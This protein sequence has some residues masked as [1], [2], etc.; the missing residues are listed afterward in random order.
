MRANLGRFFF[1]DGR[2]PLGT[3]HLATAVTLRHR[4]VPEL[5]ERSG[6]SAMGQV[7]TC[8]TRCL[9]MTIT[10]DGSGNNAVPLL[11]DGVLNLGCT[12]AIASVLLL[13]QHD[14]SW[15]LNIT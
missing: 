14:S 13:M 11:Y 6:D 15:S 1:M 3:Y 5:E 7:G 12:G 2:L 8:L 4:S 10:I 9:D